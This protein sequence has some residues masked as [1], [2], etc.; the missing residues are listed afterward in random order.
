MLAVKPTLAARAFN[1][2]GSQHC[3]GSAAVAQLATDL[4]LATMIA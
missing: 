1:H 3:R 4:L 2:T